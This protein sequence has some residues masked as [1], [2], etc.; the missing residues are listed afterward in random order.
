[1]CEQ[2]SWRYASGRQQRSGE[3]VV[4]LGRL[5]LALAAAGIAT[6]ALAQSAVAI[7]EPSDAVLFLLGTA[8]VVI[9][10][11]MHARAGR[12]DDGPKK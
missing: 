2:T 11:R 6:P 7:A 9:G 4:R 1:M 3:C 5:G 8:G 12:K 10:R